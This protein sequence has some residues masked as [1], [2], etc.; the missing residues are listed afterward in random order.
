MIPDP[1]QS[2]ICVDRKTAEILYGFV[3]TGHVSSALQVSWLFEV[4][5]SNWLESSRWRRVVEDGSIH[6]S[7]IT[8]PNAGVDQYQRR[9]IDSLVSLEFN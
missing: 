9:W 8:I 1:E 5:K 4:L 2:K 7:I 3:G 6:V